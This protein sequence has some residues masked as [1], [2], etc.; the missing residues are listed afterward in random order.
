M[1]R[2]LH[3]LF[4]CI[5]FNM[6]PVFSEVEEAPNLSY[7]K[8]YVLAEHILVTDEVIFV[9]ID[10]EWVKT[11]ALFS[12]QGGVYTYFAP[13]EMGCRKGFYPCRNCDRCIKWYYDI[14]PHCNKPA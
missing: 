13:Q 9:K 3:S 6:S 14:C 8:T 4:A 2:F 10:D 11:D 7:E 1:K 12:D 5:V